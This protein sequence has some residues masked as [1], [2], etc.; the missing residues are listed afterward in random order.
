MGVIGQQ[1]AR[2]ARLVS[3]G[4]SREQLLPLGAVAVGLALGA[5]SLALYVADGYS[6]QML[7][8]W[9]AGLAIAVV[10]FAL[11]SLSLPRIAWADPLYAAG[12]AAVE[13]ADGSELKR[14][15]VPCP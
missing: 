4:R 12:A 6:H 5:V 8:L 7:W 14:N 10:G 3:R 2:A 1:R 11:R 9:L 15:V 13:K